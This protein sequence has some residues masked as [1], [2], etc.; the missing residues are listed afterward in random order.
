MRFLGRAGN[1][2]F[3]DGLDRFE[4]NPL[5]GFLSWTHFR[6][7]RTWKDAEAQLKWAADLEKTPQGAF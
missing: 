1:S 6:E 4:K 3:T 5:T 2:V 7:A